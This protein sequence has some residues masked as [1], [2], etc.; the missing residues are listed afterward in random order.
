[1]K[2]LASAQVVCTPVAST[3][4]PKSVRAVQPI[5]SRR[6]LRSCM[7]E[8]H[9][10]ALTALPQISVNDQVLKSNILCL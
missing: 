4:S 1:M 6:P 8:P 2:H 5:Q 7:F 10:N 9:V 3:G